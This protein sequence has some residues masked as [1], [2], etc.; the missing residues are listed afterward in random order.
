M[1]TGQMS[2]DDLAA[3]H[4]RLQDA[5]ARLRAAWAER[6]AAR[7]RVADT[8]RTLLDQAAAT[9]SVDEC[10][11][12]MAACRVVTYHARAHEVVQAWVDQVCPGGTVE[13]VPGHVDGRTV[14]LPALEAVGPDLPA[15]VVDGFLTLVDRCARVQGLGDDVTVEVGLVGGVSLTIT[16]STGHAVLRD[17]TGDPPQVL[18]QGPFAEVARHDGPLPC[19][20]GP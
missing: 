3:A 7:E 13:C 17:E 19:L 18:A 10:L 11:R 6:A 1:V 5:R 15:G 9:G 12:A 20:G 2:V 16:R 14:V 8:E 4:R